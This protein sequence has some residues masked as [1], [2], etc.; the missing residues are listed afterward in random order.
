M[1]SVIFSV[2]VPFGNVV[3][4]LLRGLFRCLQAVPVSAGWL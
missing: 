4:A 3:W 1:I 2:I